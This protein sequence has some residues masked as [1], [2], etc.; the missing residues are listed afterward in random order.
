[1]KNRKRGL[2]I[3]VVILLILGSASLGIRKLLQLQIWDKEAKSVNV[4]GIIATVEEIQ[5][6]RQRAII[7]VNLKKED[8]TPMD[9]KTRV[10][11]IE[12]FSKQGISGYHTSMALS[13]DHKSLNYTFLVSPPI[14]EEM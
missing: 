11:M 13:E 14:E 6:D 10:G 2:F 3:V 4:D 5:A 1:M 8:G 9:E 7:K 12:I